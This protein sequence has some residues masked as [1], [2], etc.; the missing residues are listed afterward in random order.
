MKS[1]FDV[2]G[3]LSSIVSFV[4]TIIMALRT[5]KWGEN[6]RR[7]NLLLSLLFGFICFSLFSAIVLIS[8]SLGYGEWDKRL[9]LGLFILLVSSI[10]LLFYSRKAIIS[11]DE[12][13]DQIL[14]PRMF[15]QMLLNRVPSKQHK[16]D[17]KDVKFAVV[18]MDDNEKI[19]ETKTRIK[20][21]YKE[22][23]NLS[24]TFVDGY[25]KK[26]KGEFLNLRKTLND[27]AIRGV[28]F[29]IGTSADSGLK[30]VKQSIENYAE[31]H[32]EIP[33]A[34]C[35]AGNRYDFK[36][37]YERISYEQVG[38]F[39]RHLVL[40]GYY[41]NNMHFHLGHSYQKFLIIQ[42][43]L[44]LIFMVGLIFQGVKLYNLPSTS[45]YLRPEPLDNKICNVDQ[46]KGFQ[47][48]SL[49]KDTAMLN[50][51]VNF[52]E[53]YFSDLNHAKVKLWYGDSIEDNNIKCVLNTGDANFHATIPYDYLLGSVLKHKIFV[54]WPG[55]Y[56]LDNFAVDTKIVWNFNGDQDKTGGRYETT[57]I[58]NKDSTRWDGI[59]KDSNDNDIPVRLCWHQK[60]EDKF[61]IFGFSYDGHLAVEIDIDYIKQKDYDYMSHL[62]FRNSV[63]KYM[64][65]M[66]NILS[67]PRYKNVEN[68]NQGQKQP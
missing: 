47:I 25:S 52:T 1:L 6:M 13:P 61:G 36:L 60:Q 28:L 55:D 20:D 14:P 16:T 57:G 49:K 65:I 12:D 7:R 40:R 5:V 34:Y 42:G 27:Q 53:Y 51:L 21:N 46:L 45:W 8:S 67:L 31:S 19:Q 35:R 10:S 48:D 24:I 43:V 30:K 15:W 39:I 63:R 18:S 59:I 4:L 38:E 56:S 9:A 32:K 37:P 23:L 50:A 33:I 68:I 26:K 3:T 62:M 44:L 66:T 29:L 11:L 22:D 58:I 41:R 17:E 54:L 2:I 64:K